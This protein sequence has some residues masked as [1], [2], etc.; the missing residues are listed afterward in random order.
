MASAICSSSSALRCAGNPCMPLGLHQ[1]TPPFARPGLAEPW[2]LLHQ[3]RS[4]R[5]WAPCST[6]DAETMPFVRRLFFHSRGSSAQ[7]CAGLRWLLTPARRWVYT[8]KAETTRRHGTP[9]YRRE[10]Q[11]SFRPQGSHHV[12]GGILAVRPRPMQLAIPN[13]PFV[14]SLGRMGSQKLARSV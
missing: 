6:A 8:R 10:L 3:R 14:R 12:S 9:W 4:Y 7:R 2:A 1:L 5:A 13:V 11:G